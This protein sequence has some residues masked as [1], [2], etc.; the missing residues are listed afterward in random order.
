MNTLNAVLD[1]ATLESSMLEFKPQPI[2]VSDAARAA[3]SSFQ[4]RAREKG[5]TLRAEAAPEIVAFADEDAVVRVLGQLIDNALKF[6]SEGEVVVRVAVKAE[7][8]FVQVCDTGVGISQAFIPS[9][10]EA[11]KQES[12]GLNR[13]H[14]GSGLGLTLTHR[15]VQLIGG[16]IHAESEKGKGSTFTV[17]LPT[18]STEASETPS[19]PREDRGPQR[20]EQADGSGYPTRTAR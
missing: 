8:V 14:E 17:T 11:F 4:G 20:K 2:N 10:F 5:L 12:E 7:R 6:T 15:L 19:A 18:T 1:L 13:E 16:S 3:V 9:L